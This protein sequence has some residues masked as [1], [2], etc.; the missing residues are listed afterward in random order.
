MARALKLDGVAVYIL[1]ARSEKLRAQTEAWLREKGVP[2]D[3]LL[4]RPLGNKLN[5]NQLKQKMLSR[6]V[7]QEALSRPGGPVPL[8]A[9]DDDES[10][11]KMYRDAG[12]P[13]YLP[14]H[15]PEVLL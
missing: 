13:A 2:V 12:I 14:P 8:L 7:R 1:T 3:Q 10:V 15:V 4:M 11:V 5:D 6:L 9:V